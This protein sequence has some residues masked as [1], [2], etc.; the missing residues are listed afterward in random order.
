MAGTGQPDEF[1]RIRSSV[2]NVGGG[3]TGELYL[4]EPLKLIDFSSDIFLEECVAI[5]QI[6]YGG[7][8]YQNLSRLK[9]KEYS[10]MVEIA[11]RITQDIEKQKA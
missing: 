8:N 7:M 6:T 5:M 11:K 3:D 9:W 4:H 2:N 1:F 10:K